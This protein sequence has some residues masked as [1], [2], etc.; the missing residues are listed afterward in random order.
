MSLEGTSG[1]LTNVES[2]VEYGAGH[3]TDSNKR[4]NLHMIKDPLC[5]GKLRSRE[6]EGRP[7]A[8]GAPGAST[9]TRYVITVP[10]VWSATC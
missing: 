6:P 5:V 10:G 1:L 8:P 7:Q 4:V 3:R 9:E 2:R